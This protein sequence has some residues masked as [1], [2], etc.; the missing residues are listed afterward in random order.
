MRKKVTEEKVEEVFK[1]LVNDVQ[2]G[3][4]YEFR[5]AQGQMWLAENELIASLDAKQLELYNEFAEKRKIFYQ[6]ANEIY[7][8]K[9]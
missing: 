1:E 4:D 8:R 7:K 9:L 2:S 3:M 6:I 5:V